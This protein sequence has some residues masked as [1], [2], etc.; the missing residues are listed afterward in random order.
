MVAEKKVPFLQPF[1]LDVLV[2]FMAC[3][4]DE[5]LCGSC[6]EEVHD[7]EMGIYCDRNCNQWFH[8]HCVGLQK[9]E[10]EA[11][12]SSDAE[13]KCTACVSGLQLFNSISAV[14][15]FHF[16]FQKN[17]PMPKLSVGEQFYQRLL[18]TYLFGVYSASHQLMTAFMWHEIM[19]RRGAN[20]V[21]SC[22]SHFIYNTPL[23][24]SGAKH[25]IWWADNCPGQNKN[26][27][28]IWFFQDLIRR[29]VYSRIDYKFLIPGHTYVPA[30]RFLAI[31]EKHANKI[32]NVFTPK[33]WKQHVCD[34]FVHSEYK[35][36]VVEMQ[37]SNFRDYYESLNFRYTERTK[38][39]D[40]NPLNF[41]SAVW[42]NFGSGEKVVNN[43]VV[44]CTHLNEVWV[45]H[46]YNISEEP[47]RVSYS[48]KRGMKETVIPR[49][50]YQQYPLPIKKAKADDVKRLAVKYLPAQHQQFY[51]NIPSTT[52]D[53]DSDEDD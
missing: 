50:L 3:S 23:G 52:A 2:T 13:W 41:H 35:V 45:R 18:W 40:K 37:Q 51:A 38:D 11:L 27:C 30:D 9:D 5:F 1:P 46:T 15:V 20:D 31:I 43:K 21:I 33:D 19:A 47:Q 24:R 16:H 44:E 28:M 7:H 17:L 32:E 26:N 34:A 25:S 4:S 39:E 10:Y 53:D 48:K 14:D 12:S 49:C 42:F 36:Q 29:K 22:L 6:G 8:S